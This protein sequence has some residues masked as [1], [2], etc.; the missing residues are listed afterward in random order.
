MVPDHGGVRWCKQCAAFQLVKEFPSNK[1]GYECKAHVLIRVQKFRQGQ[2]VTNP[3]RAQLG[4]MTRA[5]YSDTQRG[6]SRIGWKFGGDEADRL[7]EEYGVEPGPSVRAIPICPEK[8]ISP[9]N[10]VLVTRKGREL[11]IKI[12]NM[13][14]D[15]EMYTILRESV[16]VK[17]CTR[18]TLPEPGNGEGSD[19]PTSCASNSDTA[20]P[21]SSE[22]ATETSVSSASES[23]ALAM[24]GVEID[25]I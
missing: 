9:S 8:G 22:A 17:K 14:H 24:G 5:A 18:T 6:F 11:A 15:M 12:W 16:L 20:S 21:A 23:V 7:C 19:T 2:Q 25:C 13:H 4:T 10:V 3:R 1:N